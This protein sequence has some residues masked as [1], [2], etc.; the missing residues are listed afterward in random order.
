LQKKRDAN[1]TENGQARQKRTR[2][3]NKR[4]FD[5]CR[6]C[7]RQHYI[8]TEGE[9]PVEYLFPSDKIVTRD[10]GTVTLLFISVHRI[11]A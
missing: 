3:A 1:E 5:A 4:I 11:S 9:I 8:Y 2:F 7:C 6:H 10:S